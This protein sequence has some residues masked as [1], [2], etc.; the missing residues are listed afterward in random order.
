MKFVLLDASSSDD[1]LLAH[2]V[3]GLPDEDGL[4]PTIDVS[5]LTFAETIPFA[6]LSYLT[7]IVGVEL[8]NISS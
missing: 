2:L 1:T 6:S 7:L 5:D 3:F 4:E 8:L